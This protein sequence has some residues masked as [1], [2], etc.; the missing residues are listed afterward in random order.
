MPA[1]SGPWPSA[2]TIARDS[3][4]AVVRAR[5]MPVKLPG[6]R[7]QAM[8]LIC[9]REKEIQAFV[10]TEYW[11]LTAKLR[12]KV[13]AALFEAEVITVDGE[14]IEIDSRTGEFRKRA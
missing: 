12:E 3:P 13:R 4:K 10:P 9:D 8:R 1:R 14:K 2:R 11:T 6:P 5:R 7:T